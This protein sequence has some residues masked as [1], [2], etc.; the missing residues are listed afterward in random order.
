MADIKYLYEI[1]YLDIDLDKYLQL[2]LHITDKCNLCC[3]YCSSYDNSKN[4]IELNTL[5]KYIKFLSEDKEILDIYYHGGEPLLHPQIFELTDKISELPGL[6]KLIFYTNL[7]IRPR[8][9]PDKCYY[10]PTFHPG[11]VNINNFMINLEKALPYVRKLVIMPDMK[12][13]TTKYVKMI[14]KHFPDLRIEIS[15]INQEDSGLETNLI[16]RTDIGD[17][18]YSEAKKI[19]FKNMICWAKKCNL[20]IDNKGGVYSC[21]SHFLSK[22]KQLGNFRKKFEKYDTLML[23]KFKNCCNGLE[24]PKVKMSYLKEFKELLRCYKS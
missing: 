2:N 7:S 24:L 10:Q 5:F 22:E 19:S 11:F 3:S 13:K 18:T 4:N 14:K 23:C 1:N 8:S 12:G 20:F 17:L 9:L 15:G 21:T 6:R 16:Y